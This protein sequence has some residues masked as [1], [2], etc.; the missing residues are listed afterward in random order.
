MYLMYVTVML[1]RASSAFEG[2]G[3]K[4]QA[5]HDLVCVLNVCIQVTISHCNT[6]QHTAT[7]CTYCN[8][9]QHNV[10]PP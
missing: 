5:L 8:T 1:E 10:C 9:L 3:A 7:H 6:L 4:D 2:D